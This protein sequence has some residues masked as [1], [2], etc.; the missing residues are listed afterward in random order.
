MMMVFMVMRPLTG[1]TQIQLSDI[2]GKWRGVF[3]IREGTESPFNFEIAANGKVYMRNGEERF[4]TGKAEIKQD[5][6]FI[7]LDQFDN[8]LAF[9]IEGKTMSGVLRKQDRSAIIAPV[10]A[11]KGISYRFIPKDK[12]TPSALSGRYEVMFHFESGRK[13]K[14]V[15]LFQQKGQR[16]TGT[17]LKTSGDT[18]YLEGIVD[19]NKFYLSSFIGSSPGYYAGTIQ[20]S[21]R[22]SGAQFGTKVKHV[23]TGFK[24]DSAALS[25]PY[26]SAYMQPG[27]EKLRFRLRD[28]DGNMVSLTDDKYRNKMVIIAITGTWCPNCIDEAA[29]LSPWYKK[30]RHRGAEIITIHYERQ[31]DTAYTNKVMRRFRERFD[32]EYDQLFGGLPQADTVISTLQGLAAFKSFP[33]TIFIDRKGKVRKIHSG[34]SGPATGKFYEEFLSAFNEE[35]DRLLAE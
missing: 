22:I 11:E 20:D 4:E 9:H 14:A 27:T 21:G 34:Y 23:F 13:E 12:K 19:G 25:D 29:F 7:P 18:R 15:A 32:I 6:L 2:Q 16:L 5:S 35:T 31:T 26:V 1:Y 3:T 10:R 17:F 33:T 24:N 30:N 28:L 8:E